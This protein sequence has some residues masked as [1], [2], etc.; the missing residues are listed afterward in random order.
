MS[1]HKIS[2]KVFVVRGVKADIGVQFGAGADIGYNGIT[3]TK[4]DKAD[5]VAL[6]NKDEILHE[7]HLLVSESSNKWSLLRTKRDFMIGRG[8][9]VRTRV[10]ENG[11]E[12]FKLDSDATTIE[13][14][15]FLEAI[16]Y[17]KTLTTKAIDLAFSGRYYI[18]MTL[19]PDAK[20]EKLQR[21][22]PFY[23]RPYR[24]LEGES[25][26]TR[27]AL[28]PNFGTKRWKQAE[29]VEVPAFDYENPTAYPVCIIDVRDIY[30]GQTYHSIGE[31]WGT[32][33]AT[34][35]ANKI[36]KF[37][38]SGLDNGYNIKYHITIP[39]DYFTKSEYPEGYDEERLKA[40]T[41]DDIGESLSGIDNVDK[42]LFTFNKVFSDGK[43]YESG[44]K[45]TPLPNPMSDDAY[46]KLLAAMNQ[47]AAS[48][49]RL[50][51]AIA[52]VDTGNGLGTSGKELESTANFQQGFLTHADR[53]LL[54]EDFRILKKI[55]NWPRDK[56]LVFKNI[57]LYTYDVTPADAAQNPNSKQNANK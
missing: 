34:T 45:I 5:H 4:A 7:M 3:K 42:V 41:L 1:I 21:I 8:V 19:G 2:D 31:W 14:E 46:T 26:V 32:K 13:I 9:E 33:D 57:E 36:P 50:L 23:C 25:R 20:V 17:N 47:A 24:M 15:D 6:G 28:N 10:I 53:M 27:Y 16:D 51:P 39:D 29:N 52:G 22:D 30:P 40:E 49:H 18:K 54:I 48:G 11:E 12:V 37:H 55:M 35:V 44:I 43:Y 38:N 56:H